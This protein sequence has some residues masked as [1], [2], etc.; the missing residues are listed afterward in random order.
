MGLA[1]FYQRHIP[2]MAA[3]LRPLTDL[4]RHDKSTGKSVSFVWTEECQVDFEGV[5]KWLLKE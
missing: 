3:I 5:K 2:N 4:T 1:N